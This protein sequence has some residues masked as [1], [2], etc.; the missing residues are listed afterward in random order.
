MKIVMI[1][2]CK[3]VEVYFYWWL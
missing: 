3:L 1:F 2:K